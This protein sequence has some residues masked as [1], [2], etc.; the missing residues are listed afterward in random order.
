MGNLEAMVKNRVVAEAEGDGAV[1]VV[2][3]VVV[4]R[5]RWCTW[6]GKR[7]EMPEVN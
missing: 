1:V 5:V 6:D 3:V 7:D 2:V 4:V